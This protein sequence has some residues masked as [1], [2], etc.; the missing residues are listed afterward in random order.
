[1][2]SAPPTSGA[3]R[4]WICVAI[5]TPAAWIPVL[6]R[7]WFPNAAYQLDH[8]HLKMRLREVAGDPQRARRWID[9]TLGGHWR[10]VERSMADLG[11]ADEDAYVAHLNERYDRVSWSDRIGE[12]SEIGSVVA[13][14]LSD[15][16]STPRHYLTRER[17]L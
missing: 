9:W 1:M 3:Q 7:E 14:L 13:F 8:Y 6:V 17:S 10:K 5:R 15:R 2:R 12:V 11:L 16:A 4:S